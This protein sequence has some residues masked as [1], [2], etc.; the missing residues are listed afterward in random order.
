M[1][2]ILLQQEG[3]GV[4]EKRSIEH[5]FLD[6]PDC[7]PALALKSY[8]FMEK[9]NRFLGG[10]RNVRT[11]IEKENAKHK[12]TSPLRILD[13]GSGSCDI[14][15]A[16]SQWA[17][18]QGRP[19][20]FICLEVSDRAVK[21]ARAKIAEAGVTSVELIQED[22]FTHRPDE[23]YDYAMASMCFHHFEDRKILELMRHLSTFVKRAVLINDLHRSFLSWLGAVPLTAFS[24]AGVK[25]DSRLSIR[26]GFKIRELRKLLLQ[27]DKVSV[28]VKLT[29]LCRVCAT[30]QFKRG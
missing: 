18:R 14:P 10:V 4:F 5:E 29:W 7:D 13:I 17:D 12:S 22:V 25:H 3:F 15:I 24:H 27:L 9:V 26:R 19:V 11:F 2:R 8:R 20:K 16:I 1:S 21:I 23:Q 28:S 30:V 6:S